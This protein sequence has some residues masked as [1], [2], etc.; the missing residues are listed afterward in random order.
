MSV[1]LERW[2]LRGVAAGAVAVVLTSVGWFAVDSWDYREAAA[3]ELAEKPTRIE[4][5]QMIQEDAPYLQDKALIHNLLNTAAENQR[6]LKR[7]IEE[8][9]KAINQLRLELAASRTKRE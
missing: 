9:T 5:K 1:E 2:M 6:D 4:V 3:K 7:V 8:N